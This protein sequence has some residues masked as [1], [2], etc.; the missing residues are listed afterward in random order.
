MH[1]Q[2]AQELLQL[3]LTRDSLRAELRVVCGPACVCFARS[4][5]TLSVS[6]TR[7]SIM[8]HSFNNNTKWTWTPM[9]PWLEL[10]SLL[11]IFLRDEK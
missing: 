11:A 2:P 5:P 10:P 9:K 3:V 7:H 1:Q 6:H 4:P 8:V